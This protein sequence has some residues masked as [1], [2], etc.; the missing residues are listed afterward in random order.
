M[1]VR[2]PAPAVE[3]EAQDV[4]EPPAISRETPGRRYGGEQGFDGDDHQNP[5]P[6]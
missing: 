4:G 3:R 6:T 5:I 1:V 2:Q